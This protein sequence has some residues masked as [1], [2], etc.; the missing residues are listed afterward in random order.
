MIYFETMRNKEKQLVFVGLSG[1]VD[2]AVAAGLL[3]QQGYKVVGLFMRCWKEQADNGVN[4]GWKKDEE[5]ARQVAAKLGIPFYSWDFV[6]DYQKRVVDYLI[7]GYRSGITPNPDVECN[8]EIKFGLFLKR[9]LKAG[10]DFVATGHYARKEVKDNE[11]KL[12]KIRDR[13]KKDPS[14]SLIVPSSPSY[15]LLKG[16]DPN[17][18]QSYFLWTLGQEQ[19]AHSLFPIGDYLKSEIRA[20]AKKWGLPVYNKPDSQGIC[21][22]GRVNVQDF[23]KKHLKTKTGKIRT[24]EGEII[25]EHEGLEL[26]TIGQ[27]KGIKVGGGI[28]YFVVDK[29]FEK[30]ELIVAKGRKALAL[31]R[32]EL[33]AANLSWVSGK[34]PRLPLKCS[35]KIRYRQPDQECTVKEYKEWKGELRKIKDKKKR[36]RGDSKMLKQVRVIFKEKQRAITPGQSIVF[37]QGDELI[38]GGII[39]K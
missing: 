18:D 17:K 4:Y 6:G 12:G 9:A 25:G 38:G 35:A 8:R 22:M 30:N 21:F 20:L 27:R 7:E 19:L 2:S 23:L 5:D 11:G 28:P 33:V 39:E 31:F 34:I 29:D 36:F 1:G 32:R 16:V 24:T 26:Y 13:N 3:K 14:L 37:Y 15:S 10:V